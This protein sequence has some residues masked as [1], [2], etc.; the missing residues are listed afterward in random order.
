M[1]HVTHPDLLMLGAK[2]QKRGKQVGMWKGLPLSITTDRM[3]L[4]CQCVKG[5]SGD[6]VMAN[7]SIQN[8]LHFLSRQ[9]GHLGTWVLG[10][11]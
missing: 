2:W 10:T 8:L 6:G 4:Q 11:T 1:L 9:E 7:A 5:K 3:Y